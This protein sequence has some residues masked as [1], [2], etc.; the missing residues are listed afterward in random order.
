VSALSQAAIE[1][2]LS[3]FISG[4]MA[5]GRYLTKYLLLNNLQAA[6]KLHVEK[7]QDVCCQNELE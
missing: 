5:V 6:S 3:C 1:R 2:D 7:M 4:T